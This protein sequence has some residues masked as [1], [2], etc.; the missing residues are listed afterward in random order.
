MTYSYGLDTTI[1]NVGLMTIFRAMVGWNMA[2][3]RSLDLVAVV[4]WFRATFSYDSGYDMASSDASNLITIATPPLD[5]NKKKKRLSF[6][7]TLEI[8]QEHF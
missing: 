7:P 8:L 1:A 2:S 6:S 4:I 5:L 3:P